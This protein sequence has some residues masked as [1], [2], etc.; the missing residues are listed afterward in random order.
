MP[1]TEERLAAVIS[2][3]VGFSG[4]GSGFALQINDIA[5]G[6]DTSTHAS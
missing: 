4:Y 2:Y 5:L 3:C 6:A 1:T